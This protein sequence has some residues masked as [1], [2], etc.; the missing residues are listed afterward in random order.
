MRNT[1]YTRINGSARVKMM[2]MIKI[3]AQ[4]LSGSASHF[5]ATGTKQFTSLMSLHQTDHLTETSAY[6]PQPLRSRQLRYAQ[7][8]APL[9]SVQLDAALCRKPEYTLLATVNATS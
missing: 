8:W 3:E 6:A 7:S 5:R 9:S 1:F 4:W 2:N